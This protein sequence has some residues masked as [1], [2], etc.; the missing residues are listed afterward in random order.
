MSRR[1]RNQPKPVIAFVRPFDAAEFVPGLSRTY[2]PADLGIPDEL[3]ALPRNA[4]PF[5]VVKSIDVERGVIAL[6]PKERR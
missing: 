1:R 3:P 2:S 5:A 4:R 6:G